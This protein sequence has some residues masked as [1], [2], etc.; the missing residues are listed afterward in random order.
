MVAANG[1]S[2]TVRERL[3]HER[4]HEVEVQVHPTR[5]VRLHRRQSLIYN[6]SFIDVGQAHPNSD[7][8]RLSFHSLQALNKTSSVAVH[9]C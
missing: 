3:V 2:T 8:S 6:R 4:L 1:L 7:A 9:H 5:M